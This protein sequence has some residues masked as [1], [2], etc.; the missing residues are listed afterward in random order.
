MYRASSW[1]EVAFRGELDAIARQRRVRIVYLVGPRNDPRWRGEPLSPEF[2]SRIV[3]DVGLRD[4]F[5]SGSE[6]FINHVHRSLRKLGLRGDQV[7]AERFA[8]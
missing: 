1:P 2:I 6:G 5:V 3:P 4:V 7:H 8:F